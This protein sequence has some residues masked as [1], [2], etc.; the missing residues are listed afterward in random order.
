MTVQ[1]KRNGMTIAAP[2]L[3]L[4]SRI[5]QD[6]SLLTHLSAAEITEL[7]SAQESRKDFILRDDA[8][9]VWNH[10]QTA[11]DGRVDWVLDNAGY[12]VTFSSYP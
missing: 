8:D 2:I 3:N 10:L 11:K 6:L 7:Q 12:E 9:A 1:G 4:L 5:T